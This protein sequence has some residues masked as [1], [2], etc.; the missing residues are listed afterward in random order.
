MFMS[1]DSSTISLFNNGFSVVF[2]LPIKPVY[3]TISV[4]LPTGRQA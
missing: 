2:F 4:N 1:F 3:P